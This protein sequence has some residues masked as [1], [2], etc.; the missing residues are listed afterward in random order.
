MFLR[1]FIALFLFVSFHS[2]YAQLNEVQK[3]K[4]FELYSEKIQKLSNLDPENL[5][6][7]F[8]KL[9]LTMKDSRDHRNLFL[10]VFDEWLEN[11]PEKKSLL[12]QHDLS[13]L[14]VVLHMQL[15]EILNQPGVKINHVGKEC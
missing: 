8:S 7:A 12:S 6:T 4:V 3:E 11:H 10:K 14:P 2:A 9:I 13:S 15:H 5:S 1:W